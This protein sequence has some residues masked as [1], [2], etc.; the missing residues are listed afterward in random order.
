MI[1]IHSQEHYTQMVPWFNYKRFYEKAHKKTFTPNFFDKVVWSVKSNPLYNDK[2]IKLN[3]EHLPLDE[4][5]MY[6]EIA[7]DA[8]IWISKLWPLAMLL[9]DV[10]LPMGAQP[11]E[12][13]A[14]DV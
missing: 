1:N 11:S 9:G 2:E 13:R 5:I 14:R 12:S 10:D 8:W 6:I 4:E 3:L 7:L